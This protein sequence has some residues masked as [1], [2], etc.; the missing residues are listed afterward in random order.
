MIRNPFSSVRNMRYF[1]KVFTLYAI[2]IIIAFLALTR[3]IIG[4]IES[5]AIEQTSNYNNL[6]LYNIN[7]L[8]EQKEKKLMLMAEQAYSSDSP[9]RKVFEFLEYDP[10]NTDQNYYESQSRLMKYLNSC[11]NE[12]I[13]IS[14]ITLLKKLDNKCYNV[15]KNSTYILTKA[16]FQRPEILTQ[17]INYSPKVYLYP[18]YK[19]GNQDNDYSFTMAM[20]IKS[21]ETY[22]NTG[23]LIADYKTEGITDVINQYYQDITSEILI[24]TKD[25]SVIYDSSNIYYGMKYP[26]IKS[27]K[28]SSSSI[29]I[30][31]KDCI[32]NVN[33]NDYFN[34]KL[35]S[36]G[37]KRVALKRIQDTKNLIYFISL[38]C[39]LI[40]ILFTYIS[41][42]AFSKRI[43]PILSAMKKVRKGDL[44]ARIPMTK[45]RD[46]L[47]EVSE[48]FN[49]M[50]NDLEKYINKVYI[51]EIK[52]KK[53]EMMALQAQI[54]PHFLYNT[55]EAIRMKAATSGANEAGEMILILSKLFRSSIKEETIT[56]IRDEIENSRLYLKLFN[57]RY[58]DRLTANFDIDDNLLEY[59][60][61]RHTIQPII[62]NYVIHGFDST[63]F[64]NT[65]II[66]IRRKTDFIFIT[67]E[68]NGYGIDGERLKKI[69]DSLKLMDLKDTSSIG[70][71]NVNERIKL[72]MNDECGIE[73]N[74]VEGKGTKVTIKML[75]KTVKEL[76]EYV[77][78]TD[79]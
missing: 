15:T 73:I 79:S 8:I 63:S 43:K 39:F 61:I 11:F 3:I 66:T 58:K 41:T 28:A 56:D 12:D 75:A 76:R 2:V 1:N 9:D 16:L 32:V 69:Q 26:Y 55:L 13:D 57:I 48:S 35:V 4:N 36:I 60:I 40:S 68:D 23:T 77:Q 18:A 31:G 14:K 19:S 67:I 25:G 46:E 20:N 34:L 7:D 21:L 65:I 22:E 38:L 42:V 74:S 10:H 51:S 24:L 5:S 17:I 27:I 33:S 70:L 29:K 45:S 78:S 44:S 37:V 53:A 6:V 47:Y 64:S 50:C 72:I 30:N 59:G 62:E 52:Q 54:N 49:A 71:L